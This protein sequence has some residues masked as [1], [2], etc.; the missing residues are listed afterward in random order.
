MIYLAIRLIYL[1]KD[2]ALPPARE[3]NVLSRPISR[4]LLNA[5]A[6]QVALG[7]TMSGYN[8]ITR[9]V[10]TALMSAPVWIMIILLSPLDAW[11]VTKAIT[12]QM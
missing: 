3:T 1:Y 7:S 5:L 4:P 8:K 9:N 10:V 11:T 6:N 2:L 12:K